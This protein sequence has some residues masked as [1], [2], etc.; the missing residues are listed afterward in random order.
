MRNLQVKMLPG[1]QHWGHSP[2]L[3]WIICPK[4]PV[5]LPDRRLPLISEM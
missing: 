3:G 1:K 2:L 5:E 4:M